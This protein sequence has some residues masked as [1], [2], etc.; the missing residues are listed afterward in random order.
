LEGIRGS[1]MKMYQKKRDVINAMKGNVELKIRKLEIE[2]DEASHCVTLY[3]SDGLFEVDCNGIRF[4]VNLPLK[5]YGCRKWD[6]TSIPC[7]QAI[8]SIWLG[9]GN[10]A[11]YLSP[12]FGKE[13]YLS[14]GQS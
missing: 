9:G 5:T 8:S 12:Y 1:F 2:E 6:V 7:G 4:V 14:Q 10:P 3:A 11:D 13:M